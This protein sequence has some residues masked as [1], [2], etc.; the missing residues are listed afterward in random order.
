MRMYEGGDSR[1][2]RGCSKTDL[3]NR[4]RIQSLVFTDRAETLF[5]MC[6]PRL[7]CVWIE[8]QNIVQ[9]VINI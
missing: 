8:Q 5:F 7:R 1:W 6:I 3:N 4:I 9:V 2:C